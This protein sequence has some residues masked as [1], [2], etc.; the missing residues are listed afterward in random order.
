MKEIDQ[1]N[2]N[3][4]TPITSEQTDVLLLKQFEEIYLELDQEQGDTNQKIQETK[5]LLD[6]VFLGALEDVLLNVYS[7]SIQDQKKGTIRGQL[8]IGRNAMYFIG[9]STDGIH[10]SILYRD[11][12]KLGLAASRS[13]LTPET[14][15]V[16][17]KEKVVLTL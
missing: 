4:N 5:K 10:L 12:N 6:S 11:V 8:C 2:V 1:K 16:G 7:A 3:S 13:V 9:S 15:E 17:T 14:M